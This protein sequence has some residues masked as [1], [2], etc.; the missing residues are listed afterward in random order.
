MLS[1]NL[2]RCTTENATGAAKT[3]AL[4]TCAAGVRSAAGTT[5]GGTKP[6]P[7]AKVKALSHGLQQSAA[8]VADAGAHGAHDD[9]DDRAAIGRD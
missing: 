5:N 3:H 4:V 6:A 1:A 2:L 7:A 8:S 9:H